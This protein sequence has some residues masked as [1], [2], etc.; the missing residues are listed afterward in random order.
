MEDE[1]IEVVTAIGGREGLDSVAANRP[2]LI[3]LDLMMPVVSG[4]DVLS[5]LRADPA[6]DRLPVVVL[7]AKSLSPVER[8]RL[9]ENAQAVLSKR[10]VGN[11]KLLD[12]VFALLGATSVLP[13]GPKR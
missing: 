1:S 13:V 7:S 5:A 4:F 12:Q 8:A 9:A 3:I 10:A 11:R 2:D 6:T